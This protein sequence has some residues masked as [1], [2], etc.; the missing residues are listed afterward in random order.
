MSRA[1]VLLTE[2]IRSIDLIYSGKNAFARTLSGY[3]YKN[4]EQVELAMTR[5]MVHC[6]HMAVDLKRESRNIV[7]QLPGLLLS[8]DENLAFVALFIVMLSKVARYKTRDWSLNFLCCNSLR[9]EYIHKN[10]DYIKSLD[11]LS[12]L[13]SPFF[14]NINIDK[15]CPQ[16]ESEFNVTVRELDSVSELN[17]KA[18][19]IQI[20]AKVAHLTTDAVIKS[21][22][23]DLRLVKNRLNL[24]Q[25]SYYI[26]RQCNTMRK[27]E[28][29]YSHLQDVERKLKEEKLLWSY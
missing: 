26:R 19:E 11:S 13:L 28:D 6:A 8:P 21:L 25:P 27:L 4:S 20:Q 18:G 12:T 15:C 2:V 24:I 9:L 5:G 3:I 14:R 17:H 7:V 23:V 10:R 1:I 22:E 16:H 29:I